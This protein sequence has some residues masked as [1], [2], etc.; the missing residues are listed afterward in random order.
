M[1]R[2]WDPGSLR[3]EDLQENSL[4]LQQTCMHYPATNYVHLQMCPLQFTYKGQFLL[5]EGEKGGRLLSFTLS[6]YH[7]PYLLQDPCKTFSVA[8]EGHLM[9][10]PHVLLHG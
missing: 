8:H 1:V 3:L 5:K 2:Q 9:D 7:D 6:V 10:Q 4:E